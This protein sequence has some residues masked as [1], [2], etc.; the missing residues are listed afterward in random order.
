MPNGP[1]NEA[2]KLP[3]WHLRDA[4]RH[5][6]DSL[7]EA[8]AIVIPEAEP[9]PEGAHL[10][11]KTLGEEITGVGSSASSTTTHARPTWF[12]RVP[13][14]NEF[15]PESVL[16]QVESEYPLLPAR[17]P[18]ESTIYETFP[19][20]RLFRWVWRVVTLQ[21]MLTKEEKDEEKRVKRRKAYAEI[22]E[23]HVPLEICLVLSNYSGCEYPFPVFLSPFF[24][25]LCCF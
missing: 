2:E 19:L 17:N 12:M 8:Q 13:R 23:S 25:T 1:N 9:M 16:A 15:D 7:A 11:E 3:L 18:P 24:T 21:K 20:L 4:H 10:K 22:V 6:V 5:L 14:P